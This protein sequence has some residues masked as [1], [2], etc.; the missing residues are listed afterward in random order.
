MTGTR[1]RSTPTFRGLNPDPVRDRLQCN[2]QAM[3]K[4]VDAVTTAPCTPKVVESDGRSTG[5]E[6]DSTSA[7]DVYE[8]ALCSF[9]NCDATITYPNCSR[10]LSLSLRP[11]REFRAVY[12]KGKLSARVPAAADRATWS[13]IH[14]AQAS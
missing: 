6:L 7:A 8:G 5:L 3:E 2:S 12:S 13:E 9:N 14:T 1:T 11:T 10:N 4:E